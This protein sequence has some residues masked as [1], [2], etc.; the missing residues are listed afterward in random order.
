[1]AGGFSQRDREW[2]AQEEEWA[3]PAPKHD[4]AHTTLNKTASEREALICLHSPKSF[5]KAHNETWW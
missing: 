1:M 4:E 2:T 5:K 3:G